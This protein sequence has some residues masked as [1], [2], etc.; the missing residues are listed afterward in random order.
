MVGRL[1]RLPEAVD[2]MKLQIIIYNQSRTCDSRYALISVYSSSK[3]PRRLES[4][5]GFESSKGARNEPERSP[6][7]TREEPES[8]ARNPD[9]I[10]KSPKLEKPEN[11]GPEKS[12]PRIHF[13]C[14]WKSVWSRYTFRA[15]QGSSIISSMP[16]Y[17][18]SCLMTAMMDWHFTSKFKQ[19]CIVPYKARLRSGS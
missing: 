14:I 6:K 10:L 7:G 15:Q 13:G 11:A 3:K 12:L 2:H 17:S 4:F 5:L 19:Y 9:K 8:L 18:K 16:Q 1:F